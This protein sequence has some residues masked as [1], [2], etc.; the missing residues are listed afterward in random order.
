MASCGSLV[1]N[2][3]GDRLCGNSN[4]IEICKVLLAE[5][6]GVLEGLRIVI[7]KGCERVELQIDNQEVVNIS[8]ENTIHSKILNIIH[9]IKNLM[10]GMAEIKVKKIDREANKCIDSLIEHG[11]NLQNRKLIFID[12]ANFLYN[13][14]LSDSIGIE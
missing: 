11:L 10:V 3:N 14:L 5:L 7:S 9:N 4:N 1:R 6:W 8:H 2:A 12:C 13:L